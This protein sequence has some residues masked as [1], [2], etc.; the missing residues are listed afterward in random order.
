M[1]E[2]VDICTEETSIIL[3]RSTPTTQ[4]YIEVSPSF[5]GHE[6]SHVIAHTHALA[7]QH[8]ALQSRQ[9]DVQNA[10]L[11]AVKFSAENGVQQ[12]AQLQHSTANQIQ[13]ELAAT[14]SAVQERFLVLE[15]MQVDQSHQLQSALEERI[16]HLLS[17]I[18]QDACTSRS[19]HDA[20]ER[21]LQRLE[22]RMTATMN[23]TY[24][25]LTAR[26]DN[27]LSIAVADSISVQ[28]RESSR[29]VEAL[30]TDKVQQMFRVQSEDFNAVMEREE[31][32]WHGAAELL[33]IAAEERFEQRLL[34]LV[35]HASEEIKSEL[36][37]A[38]CHH[39][40]EQRRSTRQNVEGEM[41]KVA[42]TLDGRHFALVAEIQA[43]F[44]TNCQRQADE[45]AFFKMS[46][47]Q[48][49]SDF[50]ARLVKTNERM[51]A[52]CIRSDPI[53]K[54]GKING[55]A[56]VTV[57]VDKLQLAATAGSL[58]KSRVEEEHDT[59]LDPETL[60]KKDAE[61]TFRAPTMIFP[62]AS[63][64]KIQQPNESKQSLLAQP[65]EIPPLQ[66]PQQPQ[67]P[68]TGNQE[69][70][71]SSSSSR[72][73]PQRRIMKSR[74]ASTTV[75]APRVKLAVAIK[76]AQNAVAQRA[77]IAARRVCTQRC[78]QA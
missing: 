68:P 43:G 24:N 53:C 61:R 67:Q 19:L 18:Q 21:S 14:Q 10:A 26:M 9:A 25:D 8:A 5:D 34:P 52:I 36:V 39:E 57:L 54:S 69:A 32:S 76:E 75:A 58:V 35:Q 56:Q 78:H 28:V 37:T 29:G 38:F 4:A 22:E 62:P 51:N 47:E 6:L 15:R 16:H 48:A 44:Q 20:Q 23:D 59:S 77:E 64:I 13:H 42:S 41:A 66:I 46:A 74:R 60:R 72:P 12:L 27:S 1:I 55:S 31:L 49:L 40:V 33:V 71:R 2:D 3:S 30:L 17:Q 73:V 45:I 70:T 63:A 50:D 65:D 11:M 7:A